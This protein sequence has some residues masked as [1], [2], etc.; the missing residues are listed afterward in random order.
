MNS[1]EIFKEWCREAFSFLK[2][3]HFKE[4]SLP[5]EEFINKFQVIFSKDNFKLIVL[6]EG[7]GTIASVF[8][9]SP[10]NEKIPYGLLDKN[11]RDFKKIK[12]KET[13]QKDQIFFAAQFIKE[14]LT[15]V[16]QGDH[17]LLVQL[18]NHF[19]EVKA[20]SKEDLS[21]FL[22]DPEAQAERAARV[23]VSE[24][25]HAFKKKNY[26]QFV[27]LLEPHIKHLPPKQMKR[28]IA[29]KSQLK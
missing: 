9:M 12:K 25:G 29:A 8:F 2:E 5:D 3:Y 13:S 4:E 7:Y 14:N 23:A 6:G 21:N 10:N 11:N 19:A 17:T 27:E 26:K 28:L 24:A 15:N 20:K 1:L 16:L 18:G 22:N